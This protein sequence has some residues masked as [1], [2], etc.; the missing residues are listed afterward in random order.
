ML[1][2]HE[3]LILSQTG[4][5]QESFPRVHQIMS[6]IVPDLPQAAEVTRTPR[7]KKISTGPGMPTIR[8]EDGDDHDEDGET[9]PG[10]HFN[11]AG[12]GETE[13]EA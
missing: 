6:R 13:S 3:Y 8:D 7:S 10:Y 11:I 5:K 1:Q 12:H 4:H 9:D 2:G